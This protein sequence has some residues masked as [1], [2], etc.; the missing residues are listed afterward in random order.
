MKRM[1]LFLATG[2]FVAVSGLGAPLAADAPPGQPSPKASQSPGRQDSPG[3]EKGLPAEAPWISLALA[4]AQSI[5]LSAEQQRTLET[6]RSDYQQR[7]ARDRESI[8]QAELDL[9][10]IL[11]ASPPDLDRVRA[12]LN[13]IGTL[14]AAARFSRIETL[15]K[16]RAVL[17]PDQWA[18]LQALAAKEWQARGSMMRRYHGFDESDRETK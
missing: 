3:T 12:Q 4:N 14:T 16:G 8:E 10:R 2:F 17:N 6:L 5:S 9:E 18:K 13:T 1:L 11:S 7:A 15:I